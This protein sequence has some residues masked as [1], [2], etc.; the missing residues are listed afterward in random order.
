MDE[1]KIYVETSLSIRYNDQQTKLIQLAEGNEDIEHSQEIGDNECPQHNDQQTKLVHREEV[2]DDFEHY[3]NI[4][5]NECSH[6]AVLPL[7]FDV[8]SEESY[9]F[10]DN[11]RI[12]ISI[13]QGKKALIFLDK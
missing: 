4:G 1:L 9:G 8:K 11:H 6:Q 7:H 3:Q 10:T 2:S 12:G 5:D 13:D